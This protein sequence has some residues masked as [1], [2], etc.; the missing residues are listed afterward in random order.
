MGY[1]QQRDSL[2]N[3]EE[4]SR[5]YG[6]KESNSK[7]SL[8]AWALAIKTSIRERFRVEK[9]GVSYQKSEQTAW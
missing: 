1:Q 3:S 5:Q 9:H 8:T 6:Y 2:K 4:K 7:S